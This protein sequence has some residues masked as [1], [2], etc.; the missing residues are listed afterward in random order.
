MYN[1]KRFK[2]LNNECNFGDKCNTLVVECFKGTPGL[3]KATLVGMDLSDYKNDIV[4]S[5]LNTS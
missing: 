2:F 3:F 1:F 5:I 4:S